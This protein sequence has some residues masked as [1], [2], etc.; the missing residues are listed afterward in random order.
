ME[1]KCSDNFVLLIHSNETSKIFMPQPIIT[2][3]QLEHVEAISKITVESFIRTY[4]D[5]GAGITKE[6]ITEA[7]GNL[8][9][10]IARYSKK[11]SERKNELS[12]VYIEE[13]KVLGHIWGKQESEAEYS[14]ETLYVDIKNLK[15]GVGGR[16]LNMLANKILEINSNA[17]ITV[18]VAKNNYN[19]IQFYE[20]FGFKIANPGFGKYKI[21]DNIIL[22][23]ILMERSV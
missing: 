8:E 13:G 23:T 6:V 2:K 18:V 19:A 15:Q 14:V 1:V 5:D 3:I 21:K 7:A 11:F 4:Q 10:L 17:K 22:D 20:H 12:F 16:L 9:K